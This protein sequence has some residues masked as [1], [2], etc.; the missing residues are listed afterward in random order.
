M[1]PISQVV[2]ELKIKPHALHLWES[3]GWLGDEPVL[4]DPS[5]NNQRVYNEEQLERIAFIAEEIGQQKREGFA[6]TD[7]VRMEEKLLDKFGGLVKVEKEE[8]ELSMMPSTA[9]QWLRELQLQTKEVASTSEKMSILEDKLNETYAVIE[10]LRE[11]N[12]KKD[13]KLDEIIRHLE[14]KEQAKKP[15]WRFGK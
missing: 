8:V 3:R 1:K 11:D 4:K 14:S 9:E 13:K 12:E 2:K 5:R 7:I 15:W 10:K 6:R